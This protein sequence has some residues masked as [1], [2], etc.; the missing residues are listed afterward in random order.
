MRELIQKMSENLNEYLKDESRTSG[1]ADSISFPKTEE[2]V[3]EIIK[4]CREKK[5]SVTIQGARTG[6][7]AGQY[8]QMDIL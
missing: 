8:R 1:Q 3:T 2:E 7:A 4:I 6:L 5:Q